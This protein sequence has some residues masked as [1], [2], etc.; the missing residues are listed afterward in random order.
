P[1]RRG[2]AGAVLRRLPPCHG[3]PLSDMGHDYA[4][5]RVLVAGAGVAGVACAEV[6]LGRGA[7]VTVIDRTASAAL[8]RLRDAGAGI[9]VAQE[10]P[11]GLLDAIDD[12]VVS[13]GFAPHTPV[14]RTALAAGLPV[15][16]EPEL[17]WRLRPAGAAPWL[18]ITGTNGKTTTTTMLASILRA[19][20][21]RTAAL[22]N[23][24]EPLV[25]AAAD[26][27]RFDV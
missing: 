6:L 3:V 5:R 17:A 9:V 2:R 26:P 13:P 24:G 21:R 11:A 12:V 14:V 7:A 23:I 8:D 10:P 4:G 27:G 1:R 25:F 20:G 15:Y 16:S 22:G 19:A 18:A